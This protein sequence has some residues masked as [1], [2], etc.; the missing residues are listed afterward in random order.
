MSFFVRIKLVAS[1]GQ[2]IIISFSLSLAVIELEQFLH[3]TQRTYYE[4]V[5]KKSDVFL[6]MSIHSFVYVSHNIFFS[7][8]WLLLLFVCYLCCISRVLS[9][10]LFATLP[11]RYNKNI[12]LY[13]VV[14]VVVAVLLLISLVF[15]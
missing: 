1:L 14:V 7:I 12:S 15:S 11:G 4:R 5:S 6:P 3:T 9:R 2:M 8:K 13:M 10:P